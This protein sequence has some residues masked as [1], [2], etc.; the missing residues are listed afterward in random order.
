MKR[1]TLINILLVILLLG[2]SKTYDSKL[3][4]TWVNFEP[5]QHLRELTFSKDEV[6]LRTY[7]FGD[8]PYEEVIRG[9]KVIDNIIFIKNPDKNNYF[10][11]NSYFNYSVSKNKLFL[12]DR[13]LEIFTKKTERNMK[14]VG[15]HLMGNWNLEFN[16]IRYEFEF[17]N[18]V[19]NIIEY[20]E[21]GNLK[22]KN[23]TTYEIN[24]P[25]IKIDGITN[26]LSSISSVYIVDDN[27]LY[28]ITNDTLVLGVL[29]ARNDTGYNQLLYLDKK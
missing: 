26:Y 11:R 2:C 15:K 21:D 1:I 22:E 13:Y 20:D 16:N 19:A 8:H 28:F 14:K 4:G 24:D 29:M 5:Y 27:L 18:D 10:F 9:Y 6:K 3:L 17:N 12:Q 25:F 7:H 23:I